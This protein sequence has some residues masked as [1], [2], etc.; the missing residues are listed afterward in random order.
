MNIKE[1]YM[2][3]EENERTIKAAKYLMEG[4]ISELGKLLYSSHQGL[5]DL[6]KVSCKELDFL[7]DFTL[8]LRQVVGARMMGGGFGGCTINLVHENFVQE[9]L[10]K[11][12]IAYSQKFNINLATHLVHIHNGVEI[13]K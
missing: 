12:K 1:L 13:L 10:D 4:E 8:G 3:S 5:R 6:Y 7:V 11:I 9:F 2:Y